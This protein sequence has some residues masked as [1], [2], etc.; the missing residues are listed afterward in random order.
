MIHKSTIMLI[1]G[2]ILLSVAAF[3]FYWINRYIAPVDPEW[4]GN[5]RIL[6]LPGIGSALGSFM[7]WYVWRKKRT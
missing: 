4:A 3:Q 5:L 2:W 6:A 7:A 1:I